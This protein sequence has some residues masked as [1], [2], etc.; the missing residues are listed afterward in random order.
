MENL[1]N[2]NLR[3]IKGL[4]KHGLNFEDVSN[5]WKYAGG[6]TGRHFNYYKLCHSQLEFPG[7]EDVC[8]CSHPIFENCYITNGDKF[9]VVGNCCIKRFIKKATRTCDTCGEPHK[10][11]TVNRCNQC[12]LTKCD[13][14]G[15]KCNEEY[16]LCY[17]CAKEKII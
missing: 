12:R 13:K 15:K 1:S 2:I 14:C 16:K 9:L 3:F 5:N 7:H 6:D 8:I 17:L 10:N 11:R 4:N